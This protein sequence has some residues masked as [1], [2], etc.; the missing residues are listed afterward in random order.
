LDAEDYDLG[1]KNDNLAYQFNYVDK[2]YTKE[3]LPESAVGEYHFI[4]WKCSNV[5]RA[6]EKIQLQFEYRT[7][8]NP[9]IQKK[10][11]DIFVDRKGFYETP[12]EHKG[13]SFLKEGRIE[14]WKVT[15]LKEGKVLDYQRSAFWT[16]P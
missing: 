12:V 4:E 1:R 16:E 3:R 7:V 15:I 8:N 2:F 6:G 13:E 9:A 5:S 14:S 11:I 10:N